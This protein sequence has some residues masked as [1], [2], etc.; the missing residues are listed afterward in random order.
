MSA[1]GWKILSFLVDSRAHGEIAG[2]NHKKLLLL[3]VSPISKNA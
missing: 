3:L 2:N 1:G